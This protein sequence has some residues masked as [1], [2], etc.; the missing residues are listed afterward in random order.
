MAWDN[1]IGT[2]RANHLTATLLRS[3]NRATTSVSTVALPLFVLQYESCVLP[4][5]LVQG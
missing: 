2:E 1:V 3:E 4:A 5:K